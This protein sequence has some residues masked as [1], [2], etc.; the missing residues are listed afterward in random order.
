M[1]LDL[2]STTEEKIHIRLS[3]KTQ[4]GK[5]ANVEAGKTVWSI[6]SGKATISPDGDGLGAFIISEDTPGSSQWKV[7]ADADLGEGV[8]TITET[9]SYTYNDAQAENLGVAADAA[10]PK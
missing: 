6:V 4:S 1:P 5:P 10:E 7:E 2:V 8:K 9:G 3:P